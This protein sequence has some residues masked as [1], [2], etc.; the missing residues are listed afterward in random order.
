[1]EIPERGGFGE[2]KIATPSFVAAA[3]DINQISYFLTLCEE[4]HFTRAAKRCGIAQPSLTNAIRALEREIGGSLFHRKPKP[5][6]SELGKSMQPRLRR[7]FA[8]I[9]LALA[10]AKRRARAGEKHRLLP[11]LVEDFHA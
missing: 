3:M 9:E 10:D 7:A 4:L 2:R 1:M 8:E 11:H 6:L 5:Q